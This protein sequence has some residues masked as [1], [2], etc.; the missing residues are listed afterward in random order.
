MARR[1]KALRGAQNQALFGERVGV[2]QPTVSAWESGEDTPTPV[3]CLL[4][5][6]LA[7]GFERDWFF[8]SIGPNL[9]V[10]MAAADTILKERGAPPLQGEIIR[11]PCVKKVAEGIESTDNLFPVAA[12]IVPNPGSTVCLIVDEN[13]AS[14]MVP[15]GNILVL[16]TSKNDV[17][18]LRPFSE[19][20]I[21]VDLGQPQEKDYPFAAVNGAWCRGLCV[22]RAYHKEAVEHYDERWTHLQY[23]AKALFVP[24]PGG[25]LNFEP[26]I[27][28]FLAGRYGA[29]SSST[30]AVTAEEKTAHRARAHEWVLD[31]M[32]LFPPAKI[33][34]IILAWYPPLARSRE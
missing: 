14:P 6:L 26:A 1:I 21:L 5:G 24:F 10:M 18:N 30:K 31:H 29:G 25:T 32:T 8:K 28:E 20:L 9:Q 33:L 16:D 4:L 17:L 11:V 34:G 15:F 23:E 12:R 2:S 13:A 19:K 3:S 27:K 22:G 7:S